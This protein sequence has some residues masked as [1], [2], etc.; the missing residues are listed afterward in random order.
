MTLNIEFILSIVLSCDAITV[1]LL[2]CSPSADPQC[3]MFILKTRYPLEVFNSP[4][5][6][7][8][9]S[10]LSTLSSE[11]KTLDTADLEVC[12]RP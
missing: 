5:F 12:Q 4:M 3:H 10:A 6:Q 7:S 9:G 2:I 1:E 8:Y 11:H